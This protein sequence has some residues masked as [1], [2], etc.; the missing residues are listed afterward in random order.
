MPDQAALEEMIAVLARG[1]VE[2]PDEVR[3]R[4]REDRDRMV[5]ELIVPDGQ[6]GQVI[7]RGGRIAHALRTVTQA[8]GRS[9]GIRA[10]LDIVD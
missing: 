9:Q 7:G 3:V 4:S 1:L 6:R 8:A 5:F 10:A 2:T